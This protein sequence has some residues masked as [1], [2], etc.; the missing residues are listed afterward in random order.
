MEPLWANF[1]SDGNSFGRGRPVSDVAQ[2]SSANTC[3]MTHAFNPS[4]RR[5]A[6]KGITS[7]ET[8]VPGKATLQGKL[9]LLN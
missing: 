8:G 9:I 7:L 1:L 6:I 5:P 2:P 3:V 4:M